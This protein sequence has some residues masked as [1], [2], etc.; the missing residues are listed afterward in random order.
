MFGMEEVET[1]V[2]PNLGT[3]MA[4]SPFAP[5][6]LEVCF[7]WHASL[8]GQMEHD[9]GYNFFAPLW[10]APF[11]LKHLKQNGKAEPGS[12]DFIA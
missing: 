2:L 3:P 11:E 1:A 10:K 5:L 4:L 7:R 6:L 9:L 12:A 8:A